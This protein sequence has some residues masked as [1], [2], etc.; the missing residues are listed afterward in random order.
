VEIENEILS[1][2]CHNSKF[3]SSSWKSGIGQM[4]I[5]AEDGDDYEVFIMIFSLNLHLYDT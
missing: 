4:A 1:R 2:E 5:E 3:S